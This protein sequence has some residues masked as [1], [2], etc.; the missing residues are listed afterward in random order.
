MWQARGSSLSKQ[1]SGE[2]LSC[3]GIL[4]QYSAGSLVAAARVI[5]QRLLH[6]ISARYL[7][8]SPLLHAMPTLLLQVSILS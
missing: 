7:M 6:S 4:L 1:L 8:D 3:L 2:C 5:A